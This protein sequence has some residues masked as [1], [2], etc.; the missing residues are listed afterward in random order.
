L[1]KRVESG[2]LSAM[3]RLRSLCFLF[4]ALSACGGAPSARGPFYDGASYLSDELD[5]R[6]LR[7]LRSELPKLLGKA[8]VEREDAA[9]QRIAVS[10]AALPEPV[11][12]ALFRVLKVGDKAAV[13]FDTFARGTDDARIPVSLRRESGGWV[14][15]GG[16]KAV[17]FPRGNGDDLPARY[18]I[19][20]L[21]DEGIAWSPRAQEVTDLALARLSPEERKALAGVPFIRRKKDTSEHLP[22][23]AAAL[24]S[25]QGCGGRVLIFDAALHADA[26]K[27]AGE[28]EAPLQSSVQTIVHEFGHA[29]HQHPGRMLACSVD[30]RSK[31]VKA[32]VAA[33]NKKPGNKRT[34]AELDAIQAEVKAIERE[35]KRIEKMGKGGPVIDAYAR[36]LGKASH[37]TR[38]GAS[39][40][41]ESFAESFALYRTDPAALKRLLPA[42]FDFFERGDHVRAMRNEG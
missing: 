22:G 35:V 29:L 36:A 33:F 6:E 39:S 2:V 14:F 1:N 20:P 16:D 27:F 34:Q 38:Y 30:R 9:G 4:L 23:G 42:V 8:R 25:V 5:A 13:E 17:G 26:H 3:K 7:A 40:L 37:P 15:R 10:P 18:G 31:A 19:G 21:R 28:P 11:A 32:R 41:V 12:V 24:Y